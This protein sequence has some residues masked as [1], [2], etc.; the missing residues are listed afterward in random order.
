MSF[1]RFRK[2]PGNRAS[3][4]SG[5]KARRKIE[6]TKGQV[7]AKGYPPFRVTKCQLGY[8]NVRSCELMK[9]PQR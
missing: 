3:A 7:R 1:G 2:E 5:N 6:K 8:L 4:A 9:T